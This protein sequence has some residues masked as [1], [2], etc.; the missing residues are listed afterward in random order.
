MC[1]DPATLVNWLK[2]IHRA[3]IDLPAWIGLPGVTE[4]SKLISLSIRIGVGQSVRTLNKQKGLLK[5]L[6][7]FRSYQ[8]DKLLTGLAPYIS[9]PEM[10]IPGFHLFSFNDVERT[11]KWRLDSSEKFRR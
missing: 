2:G 4:V 7:G 6:L 5:K 9:D 10:N 1:F 3:G 11:E 8:P